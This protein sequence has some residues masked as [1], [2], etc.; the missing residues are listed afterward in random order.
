M[1]PMV[2]NHLKY[3]YLKEKYSSYLTDIS[4]MDSV[5]KILNTKVNNEFVKYSD[6][7]I[8]NNKQELAEPKVIANIFN[9]NSSEISPIIEG[10]KGVYVLQLINSTKNSD[11]SEKIIL[12]KTLE[13]QNEIRKQFEQSYY[14]SLY[15]AYQIKDYRARNMII[16]N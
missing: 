2:K 5:G 6:V 14:P 11:V 3:N 9:L 1:E 7:N 13:K 16:N 12:S 15:D 8:G 10:K 4:N